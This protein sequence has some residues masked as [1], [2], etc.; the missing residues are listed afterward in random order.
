MEISPFIGGSR[1][2][3]SCVTLCHL[4]TK[5]KNSENPGTQRV[6]KQIETDSRYTD[7][8]LY[9]RSPKIRHWIKNNYQNSLY[10]PIHTSTTINKLLL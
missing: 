5:F 2:M 7:S 9:S 4:L 3:L 10:R 6:K 8:N 1:S